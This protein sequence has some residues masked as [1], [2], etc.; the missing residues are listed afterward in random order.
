MC[1]RDR[2][3]LTVPSDRRI[4]LEYHENTLISFFVPSALISAALLALS[5]GEEAGPLEDRLRERV[6]NLSRLFK[7]EFMF[8]AD[9]TFD[10][11]FDDALGRMIEAG[12]IERDG[13]G[14]RPVEDSLVPVYAE[15]LRSYFESYRLTALCLD[16][17]PQGEAKKKDWVK[18]TLAR[19]RRLFATGEI[20]LEEA[21]SR[22][23]IENALSAFHD[24][25]LVKVS[26]ESVERGAALSDREV[27]ARW[28]RR[29][30]RYLRR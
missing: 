6:A 15:L 24:L 10:E 28:D 12:E 14:L 20:E 1:I 2:H 4:A 11:I 3:V 27:L 26:R 9:A 21:L 23:K 5:N 16:A 29:L 18:Q 17:L 19:G 25:G 13:D 22:Q 30:K 7:Y 8:R